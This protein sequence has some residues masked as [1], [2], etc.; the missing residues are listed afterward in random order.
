MNNVIQ[1][2]SAKDKQ[3][4][5]KLYELG[6]MIQADKVTFLCYVVV[7]DDGKYIV[8]RPDPMDEEDVECIKDAVCLLGVEAVTHRMD[9][10]DE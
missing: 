1:L 10:S 5:E 6:E 2:S 3:N 8:G 4:R 7:T 9:V